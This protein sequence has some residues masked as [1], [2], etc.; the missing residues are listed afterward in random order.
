MRSGHPNSP[1][2]PGEKK[3]VTHLDTVIPQSID[4][5]DITMRDGLQNEEH[6]M[7]LEGKRYLAD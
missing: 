4:I 7:P 3:E 5:I 1:R 6:Y 2:A